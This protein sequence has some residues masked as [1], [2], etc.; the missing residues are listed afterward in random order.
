MTGPSFTSSTSIIAPNSPVSTRHAARAE[1][2]DEALVERNRGLG[3]RRVDE[4][5]P[6]ALRRVAVQ[7]ELRDD[8]QRAT[9][10]GQRE[11]HLVVCVGEDPE[12]DDLLSHPRDLLVRI[13]RSEADE[14]YE[15]TIDRP[16]DARCR[17]V[18]ADANGG[19]AD[20]LEENAHLTRS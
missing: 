15:P 11:V 20:A 8:E 13:T 12:P 10:V 17:A 16:G 5:R 9:D 7:R 4:A 3:P 18:I 2:R 14:R 6:P 1:Q 19:A